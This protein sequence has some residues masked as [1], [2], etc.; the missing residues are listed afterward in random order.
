MGE[1]YLN[2]LK[3]NKKYV[4]LVHPGSRIPVIKYDGPH[5]NEIDIDIG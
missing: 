3:N 4:S 5:P 2:N 1:E